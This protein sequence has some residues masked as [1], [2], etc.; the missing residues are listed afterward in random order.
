MMLSRL[1]RV[2][3]VDAEDR[4]AKL[5]DLVV[6]FADGDY[7][8]VTYLLGQLSHFERRLY[9][10]SAVES[11]APDADVITIARLD[12]G[13]APE[14]HAFDARMLLRR[15]ILD[16]VVIDLRARR[17]LLVNDLWL[18]QQEGRLRLRA[19]DGSPWGVLRR[20]SRGRLGQVRQSELADWTEVEFLRGRPHVPED[21]VES[22]GIARLP[23]GEIAH[24]V[25]LL[26]YLHAAELVTLLPDPLAADV[27]EAM[28]PERQLQVFEE[29]EPNQATQLLALMAPN[30]AADLVGHLKPET[31][32]RRLDALPRVQRERVVDLLR[33]P[34]DTAGG[35]MVNDLVTL[36]EDLALAEARRI[37]PERVAEPDMIYYVFV[38]DDEERRRLRGVVT[39]RDIL[40]AQD[41]QRIAEIMDTVL[42]TVHPLASAADA[43]Q[44]VADNQ[45][46]ALPVVAADGRL[47]GAVTIDAALAQLAPEGW[48]AR[49]PRV[50]S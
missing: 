40:T 10:W 16:A 28:S 19:V 48:R 22:R 7:P 21:A 29:L 5:I 6:D 4:H 32:R 35:I 18:E 24:L 26:P 9:P 37:L 14:P 30:D 39:L 23:P 50:F 31:A 44:R 2:D 41:E 11:F 13:T 38:V 25:E 36:S 1:L 34:E 8:P 27:L 43:A 45:L 15:D 49:M 17:P 20:L 33:Y 12:E 3:L 46:L 42:E 47:L